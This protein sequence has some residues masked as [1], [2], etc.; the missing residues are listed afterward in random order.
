M[1]QMRISNLSKES[2]TTPPGSDVPRAGPHRGE[3]T[4]PGPPKSRWNRRRMSLGTSVGLMAVGTL[5]ALGLHGFDIPLV[6]DNATG[7]VLAF[8]G[9]FALV[10]PRIVDLDGHRSL[11]RPRRPRHGQRGRHQHR[12]RSDCR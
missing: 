7:G 5:L 10:F 9:G 2:P 4:F 3:Q 8:V 12:G 1:T 11:F 6:H